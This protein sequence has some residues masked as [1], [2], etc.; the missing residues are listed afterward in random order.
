MQSDGGHPYRLLALLSVA[1]QQ[2]VGD[3]FFRDDVADVVAVDHDRGQ[4]EIQF[5]G[6]RDRVQF[7]DEQRNVLVAKGFSDLH[8]Q[9]AA[10]AQQRRV[11]GIGFLAGLQPGRARMAPPAGVGP[12]VRRAAEAGDPRSGDG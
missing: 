8:D 3:A 9:L 4:V 12:H 7:F 6:Q 2:Q 5:L 10:T 11:F 1:A